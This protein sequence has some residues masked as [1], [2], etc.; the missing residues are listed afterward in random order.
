MK[1]IKSLLLLSAVLLTVLLL[2]S[3]SIEKNHATLNL[4]EETTPQEKVGRIFVKY[5]D[6][7]IVTFQSLK[8]VKGI[9]A[10]PHLLADGK[11]KI[12]ASE[13]LVYQNDEHY[14]IS[15]A[16]ITDGKKSAV[17]VE[18][19]PGFAVRLVKGKLNIYTKKYFNGN[20][21]VNE[22]F[23]QLGNDGKIQK[24]TPELMKSL[25]NDD[26]QALSFYSKKLNVLEELKLLES[27]AFLYNKS[28]T[29]NETLA[30]S[31]K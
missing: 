26:E 24:Y 20:V 28:I 15:Q 3:W 5:K 25:I 19:L 21:A 2:T 16:L 17:S 11:L 29:L 13:I 4:T 14:A 1:K 22:Y 6:G 7:S 9:F 12:N 31:N 10:T 30:S 8:L 18:T 23:V 27:T